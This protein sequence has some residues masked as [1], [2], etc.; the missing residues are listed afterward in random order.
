MVVASGVC[1]NQSP[2]MISSIMLPN[3][4]GVRK[5][6]IIST[7][8]LRCQMKAPVN[9]ENTRLKG[10]K[11]IESVIIAIPPKA[12]VIQRGITPKGP[13]RASIINTNVN[14]MGRPRR[15]KKL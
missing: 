2:K 6:A 4:R 10:I 9:T 13:R 14:A 12:T 8:R 7:M 15:L 1:P 11:P 3:L 5:I